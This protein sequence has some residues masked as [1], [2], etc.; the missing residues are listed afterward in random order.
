MTGRNVRAGEAER[1]G[2]V[3]RVVKG[4]LMAAGF[5]LAAAFTRYSLRV[6]E[7]ARRAVQRAGEATLGEGLQIEADVSTQAFQTADLA[8]GMATFEQ[9]RM[10]VFRNA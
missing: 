7:F 3:N 2:L 5:D 8:E 6:L 9:N 4:A 1:I 10:P